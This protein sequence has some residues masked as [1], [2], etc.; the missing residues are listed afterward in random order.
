ME[1]F[2]KG[3]LMNEEI[4]NS[5]IYWE[6]PN[7]TEYALPVTSWKAYHK[8]TRD[9][10]QRQVFPLTSDLHPFFKDYSC[11]SVLKSNY[12]HRT[13]SL[14]KGSSL[15]N[16][17]IIGQN[18]SLGRNTSLIRTVIGDSC[19][20]GDESYLENCYIF[21]GVTIGSYVLLKDCLILPNSVLEDS[22]ILNGCIL[23]TGLKLSKCAYSDKIL[24]DKNGKIIV[25]DILNPDFLEPGEDFLFFQEREKE[26][27]EEEDS[28]DESS[29]EASFPES[30][31]DDASIFLSEVTDSL[32]RGYQDKLNCE[33]LIL[34]INSSR[35]AY[36][37]GIREVTYNVIKAILGL[38]AHYLK[39][40]ENPLS[41]EV[42]IKTLKGMLRYFKKI[43]FNYIKTEDAQ[44]DCLRAIEDAANTTKALLP[45]VYHLLH[46]LYD[47]DVLSEE[48]VTDW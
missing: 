26:N 39:S 31:A 38:P 43:I 41:D 35:Y 28:N 12:K 1:D 32:S 6:S 20:V 44:D 9:V 19:N 46:F 15:R 23:S 30:I 37:M 16:D 18:S 17:S 47:S 27:E 24:E 21:S 3:V 34:E 22:V 29:S 10:L 25:K 45:F 5:R 42:Y 14:S 13:A 11:L 48:K 33:N 36:N 7:S 4:L 2:I 40:N 8:L